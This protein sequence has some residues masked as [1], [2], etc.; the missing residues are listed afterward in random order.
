MSEDMKLAIKRTFQGPTD[1]KNDRKQN[2]PLVLTTKAYKQKPVI[3][4]KCQK[5]LDSCF[6]KKK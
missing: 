6:I 5:F 1:Y 3:Q 2:D 4:I